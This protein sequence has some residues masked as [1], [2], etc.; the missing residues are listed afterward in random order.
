M[1][2]KKPLGKPKTH[3]E[4]LGALSNHIERTMSVPALECHG[5]LVSQSSD[6]D[7]CFNAFLPPFPLDG[8]MVQVWFGLC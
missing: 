1:S 2:S 4:E 6:K 3:P 8:G 5:K 7:I